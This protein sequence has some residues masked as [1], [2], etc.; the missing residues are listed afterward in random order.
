MSKFRLLFAIVFFV[1]AGAGYSVTLR[2]GGLTPSFLRP[3][4]E[5]W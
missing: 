1:R 3:T 2:G 5:G 4:K